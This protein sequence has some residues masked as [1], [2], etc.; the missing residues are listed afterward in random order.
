M[1]NA[2]SG[3]AIARALMAG[4]ALHGDLPRQSKDEPPPSS[5]KQK[6]RKKNKAARKARK[7]N[8]R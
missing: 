1:N 8:R 2:L 6:K 4:M 7:K 3:A 5:K